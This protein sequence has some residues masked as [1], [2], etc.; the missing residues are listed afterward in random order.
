MGFTLVSDL[1][2]DDIPIEV[3]LRLLAL[4]TKSGGEA[5]QGRIGAPS[6]PGGLTLLRDQGL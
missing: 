6:A 2:A 1:A 3:S 4:A 5:P